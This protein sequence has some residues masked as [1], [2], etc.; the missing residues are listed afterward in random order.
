M[1]VGAVG[2]A[3]ENDVWW[4]GTQADQRSLAP[5]LVVA[6]QVYNWEVVLEEIVADMSTGA[7]GGRA[8]VID[9]ENGGLEIAFNDAV[10]VPPNVLQ[11]ADDVIDGSIDTG[12]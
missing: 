8:F 1:V 11:R 6:S 5:S 4:F 3:Q 9:L 10:A 12:A 2:V 7:A